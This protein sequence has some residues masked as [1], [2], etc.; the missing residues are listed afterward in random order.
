VARFY[1]WFTDFAHPDTLRSFGSEV[2]ERV[3]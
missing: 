2:I 1:V 3:G